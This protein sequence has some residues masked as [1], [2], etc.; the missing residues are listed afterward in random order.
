MAATLE[1]EVQDAQQ[2]PKFRE[3][4]PAELAFLEDTAGVEFIDDEFIDKR[5]GEIINPED[6]PDQVLAPVSRKSVKVAAQIL[7]LLK[8]EDLLGE[9]T[10]MYG[11]ELSYTCFASTQDNPNRT[12]R[13]DISI[14]RKE[15]LPEADTGRVYVVPDLI[16]EVTS[17][18]DN[19]TKLDQKTVEYLQAGVPEV[20]VVYPETQR[21]LVHHDDR[22]E[23]YTPGKT[24]KLPDLLPD[25]AR[26]VADF[27]K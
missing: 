22:I 17:P 24:I 5:T 14:I 7:G 1:A 19:V 13:P 26:D 10:E 8:A 23:L 18:G 15:R 2:L 3:L 20:W 27:F 4:T 12:R 25:F 16:V 6:D 9:R 11:S 21:V